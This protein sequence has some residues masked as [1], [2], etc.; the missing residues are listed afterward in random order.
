MIDNEEKLLT[1]S[2]LAEVLACKYSA[3]IRMET[4]GMPTYRIGNKTPRYKL[5]E[6]LEWVKNRQ[7]QGGDN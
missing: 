1:R 2:Q 4:E 5:S 6:V 7:A 3:V